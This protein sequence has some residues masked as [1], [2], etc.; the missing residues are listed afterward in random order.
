MIAKAPGK[1]VLSGAYSVL[2]GATAIVAAV[3][4]YVTADTSRPAERITDEVRAAL[5]A[6]A[7]KSAPWFDASELRATLADGRDVKLGLGSSAAILMASIAAAWALEDRTFDARA[8]LHAGLTA[9]RKAQGGGSGIDVAASTFGGVI[10]CRIR[11]DGTLAVQPQVLPDDLVLRVFAS[12]TSAST[13]SLLSHVR[14]FAKK[15]TRVYARIMRLASEASARTAAAT[16]AAAMI[17][18]L[19][20]QA[21]QIRLLGESSGAP[22]FT[23]D[24]IDLGALAEAE[25]AI[26]YPSGAGGG[27]VALWA[28]AQPPSEAFCRA[29]EAHDRFELALAFGAPGAH[30]LSTGSPSNEPPAAV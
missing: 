18:A 19:R 7:M 5:D 3:D 29:A 25:D 8:M 4:R 21:R 1:L 14:A 16:S 10:A 15:S 24:V 30:S 13:P 6:G 26:F 12:P 9:H 20:A 27:D 11:R 17:D 23:P 22:I 2:E 28:G